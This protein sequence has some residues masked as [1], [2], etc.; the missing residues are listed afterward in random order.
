[1]TRELVAF[2]LL[3]GIVLFSILSVISVPINDIPSWAYVGYALAC[4]VA[5]G[6]LLGSHNTGDES[7]SNER[8]SKR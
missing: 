6:V 7:T 8:E 2:G 1:M 5:L 3:V 4:A